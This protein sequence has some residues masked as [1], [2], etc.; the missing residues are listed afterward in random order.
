MSF[1]NTPTSLD[2]WIRKALIEEYDGAKC[3]RLLCIHEVLNEEVKGIVTGG[4][5]TPKQLADM[6]LELAKTASQTFTVPQTFKMLA[7]Y[8]DR[9]EP[10]ARYRFTVEPTLPNDGMVRESADA[11]GAFAQSMKFSEAMVLGAYNKDRM[12]FEQQFQFTSMVMKNNLDKDIAMREKDIAISAMS[13]ALAEAKHNHTMQEMEYKRSS[14]ER[15]I[16]LQLVPELI[17]RIS[18]TE[19][20]AQGTA[21]S[22]IWNIMAEK[23]SE[24]DYKMLMAVMESK[25]KQMAALVGARLQKALKETNDQKAQVRQLTAGIDPEDDAAGGK[26]AVVK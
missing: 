22:A 20:F 7:F 12:L 9:T 25:D 10:Q 11:K 2:T 1:G 13:M 14:E 4:D 24:Q 5:Q 23:M 19:V 26:L 17:N 8:G 16:L 18:G 6:F 21:D 3:T 15:R